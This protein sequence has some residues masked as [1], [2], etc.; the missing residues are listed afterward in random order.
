MVYRNVI[1]VQLSQF[2]TPTIISLLLSFGA[3]PL[4]A[5]A[6]D[7]AAPVIDIVSPVFDFGTVAQGT[8]VKHDF[9][10]ANTGGTDLIIQQVVPA[11]GCTAA[12]AQ[13]T[14]IAPGAKTVIHVEFDSSGFSGAKT[15]EAR[16]NSNDPE[17]PSVFITLQGVVETELALE[18][19]RI[20][21]GEFVSSPDVKLPEMN[22]SASAKGS[23]TVTS[24]TAG[25]KSLEV[26]KIKGSP[27][28]WQYT[29]RPAA[30]IPPGDIRDRL[31]VTIDKG[32]E[33]REVSIPVI[34]RAIGPVI[35]RPSSL[36]M[37]VISGV[38][39][40]E[41]R[42]QIES[43]RK[44]PFKITKIETDNPAV[45]VQEKSIE[46]GKNSVLVVTVD[47]TQVKGDLRTTVTLNFDDSTLSPLQFSVY[48]VQPPTVE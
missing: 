47:P 7:S 45:T 43:R 10:V 30:G 37:G 14:Q 3:V 40:I 19:Q 28:E 25:S 27:T 21:F 29:V 9:E 35:L 22:G 5:F 13:N 33:K 42:M 23:T 17:H 2:V 39:P 4:A 32:G 8:R 48:G 1:A 36:A 15:K 34:G 38:A 11:C 24:V 41:R 18:P 6:A 20:Q 31:I 12:V 26:I 46:A 44:V 16:V